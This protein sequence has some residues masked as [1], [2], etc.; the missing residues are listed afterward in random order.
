MSWTGDREVNP[1]GFGLFFVQVWSGQTTT[2][3]QQI[4]RHITH[5]AVSS[6]VCTL[7]VVD[8]EAV[9]PEV[10]DAIT[11]TG[12]GAPFDGVGYHVT[13][14]NATTI[15]FNLTTPD[16]VTTPVSGTLNY[17]AF[18][19]VDTVMH[20]VTD[21]TFFRDV[22]AIV[23]EMTFAD[24]FGDATAAI[25]FPQCTGFDGPSGDTWWL[26]ENVNVDILW[27]PATT[28]SSDHPVINPL[29]N[30]YGMFL[31]PE[32]AEVIWE[33][34]TISIDPSLQGVTLN[35]QGALF[36][37]DKYLAKP[38][39]PLVPKSVESMI[40]RYFDPMRRGLYTQAMT[41]EESDLMPYT[42]TDYDEF[43]QGMDG[44]RMIPSALVP[45][46]DNWTG[47]VTRNTGGW[48]P[49]LTG[50][51][52]G[53]LSFMYVNPAKKPGDTT[54]VSGDQWTITKLPGRV[55]HMHIRRQ[56]KEPTLVAWYGQPGVEARLSRDAS[57]VSNVIFGRGTG[58]DRS[59][60]LVMNQPENHEW[61]TWSP[62]GAIPNVHHW[63]DWEPE[64][65]EKLYEGYDGEYERQNDIWVRERFWNAIPPG[66]DFEQGQD[67]AA[68]YIER[69]QLPGWSGDITLRSDLK[70]PAGNWRS[71]WSIKV[72]D[73]IWLKGF[74]GTDG[75]TAVTGTNK[76][77]VSQVS[78]QPT[79]NTVVLTV[80]TK[81][82]DLLTV[83]EA[84]KNSR[85]PLAP[86][87][88]LEIGKSSVVVEDLAI[89]WDKKG[90][91][92]CLPI[93]NVKL[94]LN[95]VSFPW[96]SITTA[97]PP[98]DY[99][100]PDVSLAYQNV[101]LDRDNYKLPGGMIRGRRKEGSSDMLNSHYL[102]AANAFYLPINCGNPDPNYR[103]SFF[104]IKLSQAG[105][106]N[107][108]EIAMYD[109]NGNVIPI[110]FSVSLWMQP[111]LTE[112]SMPRYLNGDGNFVHAALWK[113]AFSPT[114][115]DSGTQWP[116]VGEAQDHTG[117]SGA[118]TIGWGT[119]EKPC[120]YEP[121]SLAINSDCSG[122]FR[123]GATWDYNFVGQSEFG[124]NGTMPTD[125]NKQ[126]PTSAYS[127]T[128]AIYAEAAG[129]A[130]L[131][132]NGTTPK[133]CY[134][135]GRFYR[136]PQAGAN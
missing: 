62:I 17:G 82:R 53:Q 30:A 108:V 136:Q 11:I 48:E 32:D 68:Q 112:T 27:I 19:V 107:S 99:L 95:N 65:R 71:K 106:I 29:T 103:W 88:M 4:Q 90:G 49:A 20:D 23:R 31:H 69:D 8:L 2:L 75:V 96:E 102:S 113:G 24:P 16:V 114:D 111:N 109:I 64:L 85:D 66:I 97:H 13:E 28:V 100:D 87:K 115:P 45:G 57:Q 61:F 21:V 42:Q 83:E 36:Q 128:V 94:H 76:F 116:S 89:P 43:A 58:Y 67:I 37:V 123:D 104:P 73:V 9:E 1:D 78:M 124:P 135:T 10:T 51:I 25:D 33:G 46:Q 134:A 18:Y 55:P 92:G 6:D 131:E 38:L 125:P 79:D 50:Y 84:L 44:Y 98:G 14:H 127:V 101:H 105:T 119:Y 118:P 77:H 91:S 52:Q 74:Y 40:A 12:L 7:T 22:P 93:K 72:G 130:G 39:Y 60:W 117:S 5:V 35:C 81:F 132:H 121:G 133:W 56:S 41:I 80:D 126:V 63:D 129:S 15:K 34:F 54:L 26:R 86:V 70:D 47:Y 110:Q 3:N 122:E 59:A 120:G